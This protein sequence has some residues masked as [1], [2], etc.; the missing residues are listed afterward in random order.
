MLQTAKIH[1]QAEQAPPPWIAGVCPSDLS[2]PTGPSLA[3]S[4]TIANIKAIVQQVLSR[5]S[6]ALSVTS[7]NHSWFFDIACSSHMTPDES[8]FS[9]KAPL[10]HPISIYTSD[11]TPMPVSHKGTISTHRLS[12]SDTFHIPNLSFNLLSVGQLY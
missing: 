8:Q 10:A 12:L 6:V 9:D 3:S 7:S 2:I 5:T 4:C 1:A 11:G